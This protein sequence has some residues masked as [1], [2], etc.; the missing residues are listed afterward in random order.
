MKERSDLFDEN[1]PEVSDAEIVKA[2]KGDRAVLSF[3]AFPVTKDSTIIGLAL[4]FLFDKKKTEVVLIDRYAANVLRLL[5]EELERADWK[6]T[7]TTP[8]GETR[9]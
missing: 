6:A 5:L 8:P 4:K 2:A 7:Q 9:H 3:G 1:R